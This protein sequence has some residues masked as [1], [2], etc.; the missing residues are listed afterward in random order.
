MVFV[1]ARGGKSHSWLTPTI[2][3][4]NPSA[5]RI[6]VADGSNDTIRMTKATL[7]QLCRR[8]FV[9][10]VFAAGLVEGGQGRRPACHYFFGRCAGLQLLD[11]VGVSDKRQ[12]FFGSE[13]FRVQLLQDGG[14]F[15][16]RTH[17]A[18]GEAIGDAN[19]YSAATLA[20]VE[21]TDGDEG[22][23]SEMQAGEVPLVQR[24]GDFVTVEPGRAKLLK[25]SLRATADGDA[26]TL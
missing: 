2:S 8:L 17:G 18:H 12:E 26:G 10:E 13:L 23:R 7:T 24:F 20:A 14:D 21:I 22:F 3:R 1:L 6:S 5:K 4:S 19:T 9:Q 25:R 15:Q 16:T 11:G